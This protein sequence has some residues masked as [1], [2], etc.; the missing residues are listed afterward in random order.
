MTRLHFWV[1]RIESHLCW[2]LTQVIHISISLS[3]S[4]PVE[5]F[6]LEVE[7]KVFQ[8]I[9]MC[10]QLEEILGSQLFSL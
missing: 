3:F 5:I 1:Y 7:T 2:P 10:T 4:L 8:I 9:P 6:Y